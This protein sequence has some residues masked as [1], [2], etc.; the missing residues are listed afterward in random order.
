MNSGREER[1]S[2]AHAASITPPAINVTKMNA[3][4]ARYYRA[5]HGIAR[6][7]GGLFNQQI[8]IL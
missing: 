8:L 3:R 4:I 5:V 7:E 1:L 6:G 2:A